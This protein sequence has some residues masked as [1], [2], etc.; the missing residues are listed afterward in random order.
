MEIERKIAIE[1]LDIFE[2]YLSKRNV[3]IANSERDEYEAGEGVEKS[4]LFGSD[5][6]EL[7][8]E[9][10]DLLESLPLGTILHSNKKP[11]RL[12]ILK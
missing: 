12:I 6:F 11:N 10:T 7:E 3:K 9:V 4:I 8:D 5:Y 2:D 1:I